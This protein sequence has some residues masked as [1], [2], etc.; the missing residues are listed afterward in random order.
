MTTMKFSDMVRPYD[1]TGCIETW[2]QKVE[3]VAELKGLT[4]L[5]KVIPLQ[6][7]GS[8][9]AVFAQMAT[10]DKTDANKVKRVLKAAFAKDQFSAYD[11]FRQRTWYDGEPV[12]VYLSELR[13]LASLAAINDEEILKCAFVVGLPRLVSMQLRTSAQV[14]DASLPALVQQAR[15]CMAEQ[16]HHAAAFA[17]REARPPVSARGPNR[18]VIC[19]NCHGKGHIARNCTARGVRKDSSVASNS[20]NG[21]CYERQGNDNGKTSAPQSSRNI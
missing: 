12:D 19:Y 2:L 14:N 18:N 20:R 1:G 3:L 10:E 11:E 21:D 16:L 15:I 6:L 4:D 9:F 7:E 17:L 5:A 8:A 13:R